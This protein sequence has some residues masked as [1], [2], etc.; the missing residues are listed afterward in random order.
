MYI[1][2]QL[3]LTIIDNIYLRRYTA[4]LS[5]GYVTDIIRKWNKYY[6]NLWSLFLPNFR[7]SPKSENGSDDGV[8]QTY[9][10]ISG[11]GGGPPQHFLSFPRY[12]GSYIPLNSDVSYTY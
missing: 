9:F 1:I 7:C 11:G 2:L 8:N 6:I 10:S 5:S 4:T 12:N 3:V